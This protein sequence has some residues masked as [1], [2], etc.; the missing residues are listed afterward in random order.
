MLPSQLV[1]VVLLYVEQQTEFAPMCDLV[2][3]TA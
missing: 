1:A 2:P 3:V